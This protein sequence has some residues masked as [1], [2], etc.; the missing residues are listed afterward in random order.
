VITT[1]NINAPQSIKISQCNYERGGAVQFRN[2]KF[3]ETILKM[4]GWERDKTYRVHGEFIPN[5]G[6]VVFDI[7]RSIIEEEG[8]ANA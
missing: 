3:I 8:T 7:T 2:R 1:S 5:P 6:A 4:T